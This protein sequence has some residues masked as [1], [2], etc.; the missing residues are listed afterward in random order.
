MQ[1]RKHDVDR[2]EDLSE[3]VLVESDEVAVSGRVGGEHQRG[4]GRVDD[5]QF[6][7]RHGEL[8]RIGACEYPSTIHGDPDRDGFVEVGIQIAQD[9]ACR[10][11]GDG[12]FVAAAAEHDSHPGAGVTHGTHRTG[13]GGLRPSRFPSFTSCAAP[14]RD[15]RAGRRC[16]RYRTTGAR[17]PAPPDHPSG[18]AD[19]LWCES[20]RSWLQRRP[21]PTLERSGGNCRVV[22][23]E[24]DEGAEPAHLRRSDGVSRVRRQ[25][26]ITHARGSRMRC[27]HLR[28]CQRVRALPLEAQTR[29]TETSMGEPGLERAQYGPRQQSL[30]IEVRKQRVVAHGDVPEQQIAVPAERF[31]AAGHHDIGAETEWLLAEGCGRGVVDEQERAGRTTPRRG[32]RQVHGIEA[33]VRRSLD[34]DHRTFG[35]IRE[36]GAER[37][38][39]ELGHRQFAN[40]RTERFETVARIHPHLVVPVRRDHDHPG[41]TGDARSATV[42]ADIPEPTTRA[43]DAPSRVASARSRSRHPGFDARA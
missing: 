24:G 5:G 36:H 16:P 39:A 15:L 4:P 21:A 22:E 23:P 30:T 25:A 43:A 2:R 42:I 27:Q 31:G 3:V 26:R 9:A 35:R 29:G 37:A 28:D 13:K 14:H 41:G 40:R 11:T 32:R 17:T 7:P 1:H 10:D 20:R 18:H 34:E 12:M 8:F 19:P 33:R 38:V 6:T